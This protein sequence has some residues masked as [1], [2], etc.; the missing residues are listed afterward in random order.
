[1]ISPP[2]LPKLPDRRSLLVGAGALTLLAT[3]RAAIGAEPSQGTHRDFWLAPRELWLYRA[4]TGEGGKYEYWRDGRLQTDAWFALQLVFR[5]VQAGLG[6]DIDPSVV[7][8]V[9]AVQ[10]WAH[11]DS[12]KRHLFRATSGARFEQTNRKT[13]GADPVSTHREGRAIDGAF[14]GMELRRY[15]RAARFFAKGGVG[16]YST[17]VHVDTGKV[18]TWGAK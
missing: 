9:W 5:D 11:L 14:E 8:L 15:A 13:P 12:G 4:E 2:Q 17:H 18:R 16:L 10:R 3:S 1:M 6:M 7:D